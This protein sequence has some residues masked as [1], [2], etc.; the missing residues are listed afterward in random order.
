MKKIF[1]S[2][3]ALTLGI[4][5][6]AAAQ[7]SPSITDLL[8]D[9]TFGYSEQDVLA[10]DSV[11]TTALHLRSPIIRYLNGDIIMLYRLTYSPYLLE[12]LKNTTDP[13]ILDQI[14]SKDISLTN[15]ADRVVL[16]L[17][18]EDGLDIDTTYYAM[19]T[20]IDIYDEIGT[21]SEQVC[22]NLSQQRYEM[23]DDCLFFDQL[24]E[25]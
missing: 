19:V 14:K 18:I 6:F 17:G 10:V 24:S 11:D 7:T 22:F 25:D 5:T 15:G 1:L 12:D 16:D 8:K 13:A 9:A 2:V 4:S 20:P 3:A 23:G 21:S